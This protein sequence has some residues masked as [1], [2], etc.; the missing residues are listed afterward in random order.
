MPLWGP[1]SEC[2]PLGWNKSGGRREFKVGSEFVVL[3]LRSLPK[4]DGVG[5]ASPELRPEADT[6]LTLSH[7]I[8]TRGSTL[9]LVVRAHVGQLDSGW[10][11]VR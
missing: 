10:V 3:L 11:A 4:I 6:R 9:R 1:K 8:R 7:R 5:P 2:F